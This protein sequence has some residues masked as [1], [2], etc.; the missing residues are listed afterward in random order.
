MHGTMKN[1]TPSAGITLVIGGTGKTGRRVAE[2]LMALGRET[3]VASRSAIPS[4]DWNN[5][6]TWDAVLTGVTAAYITY[7]PDLAIPGATNAIRAFTARAVEKGVKRLVLLSGRGE[8]EARACERIVQESGVAWTIVRASWFNQN[9]SEGEFL[10]MVLNGAITLPANDIPVPFVD[11][12]DIAEV[13]VAALTE[14]G[15]EYETYE[16]TGPRL[17]TFTE[18]A[19]EISEAAGR[20]VRF[21][22]IPQEA[23]AEAVAESG[24]PDGLVWLLGYLFETV[25]DGR[26]AY[27]GDGVQRALGR[28]PIDFV[29]YARRIGARG[30]WNPLS[31]EAAA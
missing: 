9:F 21:V 6:G 27:L 18:V 7:A 16:V 5:Q 13:A 24:A 14:E 30:T 26:N 23:F 17:L 1:S 25:L 12:E 15:H 10:G 28:E 19:R 20:E 31:D 29:N 8:E 4:F 11:A 2:R 22:Q 3:R